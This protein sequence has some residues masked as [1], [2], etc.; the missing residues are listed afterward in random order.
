MVLEIPLLRDESLLLRPHTKADADAVVARSVDPLTIAWTTVPLDYTRDMALNYIRA[1][2]TPQQ[3]TVSWALENGG[4]YAGSID[5]RW[6]GAGTG[7]LG[8]VT[9][10]EF[11]GQGLMSRAVRLAVGYAFD[12][13]GWEQL[14]WSSNV[15]NLGSYKAVWRNGFPLP[16]SVPHM[17][18]HR[19]Q[20]IDGWFSELESSAPRTPRILWSDVLGLLPRLPAAPGPDTAAS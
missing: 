15:G 9:S 19:G 20:M 6:Q 10:P 1:V 2:G 14:N 7:G 8:F 3:D 4:R 13:L 11:R 17:L 16:V 5:L 18:A 12:T